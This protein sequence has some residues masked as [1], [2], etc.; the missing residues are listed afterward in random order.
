MKIITKSLLLLVIVACSNGQ[1][2]TE[3]A[4]IEKSDNGEM[5]VHPQIPEFDIEFPE[6]DYKVTKTVNTVEA[7][8]GATVTNWILQ[9][10]NEN[11]PFLYYVA[12]NELSGA[13]KS[14]IEKS[15]E[16]LNISFEAALRGSADKLGAADYT[17]KEIKLNKYPGMESVC[18]VFNGEGLLKSRVYKIENSFMMVSAGGRNVDT[19]A[20]NIFL[21]SFKLKK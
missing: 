20:V 1:Y 19:N 21:N 5:Q 15:P 8:G 11:G 12:H 4:K 17:F 18:K 6:S 16:A 9:G 14:Q 3:S 7:A 10:K 13:L 2:K